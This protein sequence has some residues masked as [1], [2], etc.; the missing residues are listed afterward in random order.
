MKLKIGAKVNLLLI[1]ALFIV[2]G[3]SLIFSISSLKK[4]GKLAIEEYRTS[5]MQEKS[6]SLKNL[7]NSAYAIAKANYDK[8]KD[9]KNALNTIGSIRFGEGN[10][11]YFFIMNSKGV[12]QLH[13]AK[14][15][16]VGKDM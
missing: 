10:K 5:I 12:L 13:P 1:T 8:S 16:L 6:D 7:V 4:Q 2:G 3:V 15:K 14:P 9:K 11:N